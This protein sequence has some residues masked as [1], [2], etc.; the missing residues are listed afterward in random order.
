MNCHALCGIGDAVAMDEVCLPERLD[1]L[2]EHLAERDALGRAGLHGQDHH[3]VDVEPVALT[4]RLAPLPMTA[5]MLLT[6]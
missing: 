4:G 3:L 5:N 6:K 1:Q 2:N